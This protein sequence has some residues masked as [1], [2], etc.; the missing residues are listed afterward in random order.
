MS[1]FKTEQESFWNGEFGDEYI[2][3]NND[4]GLLISNINFFSQIISK[5][6]NV[7][8]AL[9]FGANIGLNLDVLNILK[10]NIDLSGIEINEKAYTIL[11]GKKHVNGI[12]GSILEYEPEEKYDFV[13]TKTVL[14]H[15]NPNELESVYEKLYNASSRYICIA[16]YYSQTPVSID[17]RGEKERLFKRDFAGELLDKYPKL[18]LIDYGFSY[19][20]DN[21]FPQDDITWFLLEKKRG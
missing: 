7:K 21:N 9:E 5:T 14:I 6:N 18:E 2:D 12:L 15:I 10:P 16:E 17:Y 20:R 13:F 19:G 4:Q 3:R 8:S 11:S 1:N